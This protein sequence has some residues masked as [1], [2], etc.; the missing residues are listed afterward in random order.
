M[1]RRGA[2][3]ESEIAGPDG[4][5]GKHKRLGVAAGSR[6]LGCTLTEVPPGKSPFPLHTHYAVEEAV[7]VL[8]GSGTLR[9]GTERLELRAGDYVAMPPGK[10]FAHQIIN[11]GDQPLRF[12]CFST[13]SDLDIVSYPDSGKVGV[14][15]GPSGEGPNRTFEIRS[16]FDVANGHQEYWKGESL[17]S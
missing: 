6:K 15:G 12:L 17:K 2:V 4:F 11:T 1:K 5:E 14:S 13:M 3:H 16:L 7:F 8:S 9:L 10:E